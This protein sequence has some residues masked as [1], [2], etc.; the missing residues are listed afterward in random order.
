MISFLIESAEY[1]I[2]VSAADLEHHR[3]DK[4]EDIVS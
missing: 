2:T 1:K 4:F 3:F